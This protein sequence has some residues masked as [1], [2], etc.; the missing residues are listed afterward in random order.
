MLRAA[1]RQASR[2]FNIDGQPYEDPRVL[3]AS[4]WQLYLEI[5]TRSEGEG[6]RWV[7][8]NQRAD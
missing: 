7:G 6:E 1:A 8:D 2:Q 3:I 4:I 5:F